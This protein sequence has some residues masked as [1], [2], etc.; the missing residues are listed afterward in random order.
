MSKKEVIHL[1]KKIIDDLK[2]LIE[3]G[4]YKKG[5]LLPSENELCKKN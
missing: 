3:K 4:E 2:S 5:D 1:Y